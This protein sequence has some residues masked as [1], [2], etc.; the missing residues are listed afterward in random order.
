MPLWRH[1]PLV[2]RDTACL[3]SKPQVKNAR[4]QEGDKPEE[5][6]VELQAEF[7]KSAQELTQLIQ[8]INRT[9]STA[10]LADRSLADSLAERDALK[11][12]YNAYREL[13]T[14]ASTTQS[15]MTRSEV[16]FISTVSVAAIQRKADNL[17]KQYR[18]LDTSIQEADWTTTLLD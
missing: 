8:R 14:A 15:R 6:P 5:D 4:I 18:E 11:I 13:A 12:R 10:R 16:K 2:P 3:R 1:S 7:E 17:A 9:N